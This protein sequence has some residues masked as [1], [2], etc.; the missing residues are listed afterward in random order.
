MEKENENCKT[1]KNMYRRTEKG[2]RLKSGPTQENAMEKKMNEAW[3]GRGGANCFACREKRV[4]LACDQQVLV[5]LRWRNE[6]R[7]GWMEGRK[8]MKSEEEGGL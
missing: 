6:R 7:E 5:S 8:T 3:G 2:Y 4:P 1:R